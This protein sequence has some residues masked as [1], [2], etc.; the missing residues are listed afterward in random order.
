MDF[1]VLLEDRAEG[2]PSGEDLEYDPVFSEMERLAQPGQERQAGDEILAPEEPDWKEVAR[3]VADVLGRSHDLRAG[4]VYARS[5]LKLRGIAG[6]VQGTG[7]VRGCLERHWET[8]HPQLDA[9]D[10]DDPTMRINAVLSLADHSGVISA[11]RRAPLTQSRMFG[12]ISLRDILVAEGE[13]ASDEEGAPDAAAVSAAFKDTGEDW[14]RETRDAARAAMGDVAAI[15][16]VFAEKTPGQGPDLD[17]L[18]RVLRQITSRLDAEMGE[19]AAEAAE[20]EAE[21]SAPEG[22]AAAPRRGGA[23]A[24]PGTIGSPEDVRRSIDLI[25]AY[26]AREEPSSP[27]PIFLMRARKLVGADFLTIV[28][29]MTPDSIDEVKR[30][31]SIVDED[32]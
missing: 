13:I 26:Y 16:A 29:D 27:V 6:F 20:A 28:Q 31:G 32:E 9:D 18:T 22:G 8:C 24:P 15:D 5:E 4:V 14:L 30:L 23:S 17:P 3:A 2:A 19:E 21:G 12:A 25:C 11:L 7:Y 1:E 10:D